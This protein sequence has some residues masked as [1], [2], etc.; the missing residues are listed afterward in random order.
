MPAPKALIHMPTERGRAAALDG[1]QHF[2]VRPGKPL[3]A[4]LD[5]FVSSGADQIGH[6]QRRPVHLAVPRR[7]VFLENCRQRE[8]VQGTRGG[9]EMAL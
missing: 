6:F 3:A 8:R 2:H 5:E 7:V 1:P 4:A 9:V